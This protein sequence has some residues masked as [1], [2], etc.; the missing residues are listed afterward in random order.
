MKTGWHASD[1]NR[2]TERQWTMSKELST[3]NVHWNYFFNQMMYFVSSQISSLSSFEVAQPKT[4]GLHVRFPI[5]AKYQT[6]LCSLC[7]PSV[8][9]REWW[10]LF[11]AME[12]LFTAVVESVC[13]R[14]QK[15]SLLWE[16][17][18]VIHLQS[19]RILM[20]LLQ[21]AIKPADYVSEW[22]L[23]KIWFCLIVA[24]L[25][26]LKPHSLVRRQMIV[27]HM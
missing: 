10:W 17:D 18:F 9:E 7:S 25:I 1:S 23:E 22:M 13:L 6:V 8:R 24:L 20:V 16:M 2:I 12:A 3:W 26:C 4:A 11:V 14:M 5:L 15:I 21:S 27:F 19:G